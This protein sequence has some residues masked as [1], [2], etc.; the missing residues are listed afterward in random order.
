MCYESYDPLIYINELSSV[1]EKIEDVEYQEVVKYKDRPTI[2]I[3]NENKIVEILLK[4]WDKKYG[5]TD[6]ERNNNVYVLASAFNDFGVNQNL[7]EYVMGNY[8]TEDFPLDEILRTISSAYSHKQNFGTKYYEDED[9]V[10][11]IKQKFRQGVSKKELKEQLEKED[12]LVDDLEGVLLRIEDENAKQKF[13]TKSDKGAIKIIHIDFKKFLEENGFYKFNPEGSKNYVFVKV[14]NNLIDHTSEKEIKDFI[15]SWKR[16]IPVY[17]T[18]S[19][20]RP[21]T[22]ERSF[23]H[24]YLL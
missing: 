11:H 19:L 18:T 5:M 9:K 6:G 22:S 21:D 12:I 2:P 7:A 17:T 4:W 20:T 24:C 16:M 8:A 3:T 14:T 15:L 10:N 1:W 13:W 23:S